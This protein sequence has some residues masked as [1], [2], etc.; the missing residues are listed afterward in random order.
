MIWTYLNLHYIRKLWPHPIFVIISPLKRTWSFIWTILNFFFSGII[1]TKFDWNWPVGS[2]EDL[3]KKSVY[4]YCFAIISPCAR[5][6][7]LIW[8]TLNHFP[9]DNL[10]QVWLKLTR[11]FWRRIQNCKSLPR[12]TDNAQQAIRK[13]H[14]QEL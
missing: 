13:A 1:C 12:Q 3:K 2:R 8:T 6:F 11:W 4:I 5:V 7:P 14:F 10:S 9:K